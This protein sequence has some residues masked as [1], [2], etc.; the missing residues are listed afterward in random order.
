M[1]LEKLKSEIVEIAKIASA[2]PDRFQDRCFEVLLAALLDGRGESKEHNL[3]TGGQSKHD[4]ESKDPSPS[5]IALPS[6]MKAFLRR[7]G[8]AADQLEAVVMI[9]DG[10][11]HFLKEPT[12]KVAKRGQLEWALLL[13]AKNGLL[14][15]S[16]KVDPEDVRSIVQEKGYYDAKNF[17]SNFKDSKFITY[18]RNPLV[19]QGEAQQLTSEGEQALADLI[20]SLAG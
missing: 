3:G 5:V 10:S 8:I 14:E 12:H 20:K 7:R 15:N 6:H 19:P 4:T 17:A 16:L 2:V 18:F 9:E 13:A 1:E 11:L